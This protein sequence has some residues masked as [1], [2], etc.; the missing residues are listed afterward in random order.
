LASS[1]HKIRL[2]FY[3]HQHVLDDVGVTKG[4]EQNDFAEGCGRKALTLAT[5]F[6]LFESELGLPGSVVN[7]GDHAEGALADDSDELETFGELALEFLGRMNGSFLLLRLG[8][9][10]GQVHCNSASL[11]I[12]LII[13]RVTNDMVVIR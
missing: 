1:S 10:L 8:V 5:E 2:R 4:L 3:M 11:A 7:C 13:I 12:E 9:G 6:D